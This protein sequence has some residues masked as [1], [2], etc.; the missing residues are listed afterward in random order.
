MSPLQHNRKSRGSDISYNLPW[1]N[2]ATLFEI[3]ALQEQTYVPSLCVRPFSSTAYLKEINHLNI[4][5]IFAYC[6]SIGF[7]IY[8]EYCSIEWLLSKSSPI[9]S[10]CFCFTSIHFNWNANILKTKSRSLP[11]HSNFPTFFCVCKF[12]NLNTI[13]ILS[14]RCVCTIGIRQDC[15]ASP[16]LTKVVVSVWCDALKPHYA[17]IYPWLVLLKSIIPNYLKFC[18]LNLHSEHS[19]GAIFVG[20]IPHC[21]PLLSFTIG[22]ICL[23]DDHTFYSSNQHWVTEPILIKGYLSLVQRLFHHLKVGLS[24]GEKV[25]CSLLLASNEKLLHLPTTAV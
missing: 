12:P 3:K 15:D 18:I 20:P 1:Y 10:H 11:I 23:M 22:Y 16:S 6:E 24:E 7:R 4:L 21:A 25:L 14:S 9:S 17:N 19:T 5:N 8:L 2:Y 13:T